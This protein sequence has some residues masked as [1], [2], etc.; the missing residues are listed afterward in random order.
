[1]F[2]EQSKT[3]E[4]LPVDMYIQPEVAE[5]ISLPA[6]QKYLV[7][8]ITPLEIST[9]THSTFPHHNLILDPTPSALSLS[10]SLSPEM[11]TTFCSEDNFSISLFL[12]HHNHPTSK[13]EPKMPMINPKP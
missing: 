8:E 13:M 5:Q 10:L 9:K 3:L 6:P 4:E 7:A 2:S 12:K 11:R 1:L